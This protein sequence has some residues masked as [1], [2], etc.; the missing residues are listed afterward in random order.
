MPEYRGSSPFMSP[1]RALRMRHQPWRNA[2]NRVRHFRRLVSAALSSS[3]MM[4][5]PDLVWAR[6]TSRTGELASVRRRS[7]LSMSQDHAFRLVARPLRAPCLR[8]RHADG[9]AFTLV[10]R[11]QGDP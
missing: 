8:A 11:Y 4:A 1:A 7:V 9:G 10:E 2:K 6:L 3:P 5:S